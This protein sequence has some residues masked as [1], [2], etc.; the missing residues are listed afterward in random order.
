MNIFIIGCIIIALII[1]T[2]LL[3]IFLPKP[4]CYFTLDDVG[5]SLELLSQPTHFQQILEEYKKNNDLD[6]S[7]LCLLYYNNHLYPNIHKYSKLH[8]LIQSIPDIRS[9]FI[10]RIA[11]K[12]INNIKQRGPAQI[13]NY[14]LRCILPLSISSLNKSGIWVDGENRFFTEQ[15]WIIYDNSRENTYY[16]KHKHRP[17]DLLIIDIDRPAYIPIGISTE[18]TNEI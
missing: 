17:T 15:E 4:K 1:I 7:N 16:N 13:A 3:L 6:Q 8:N 2:M 14:T 12:T 11:P 5:R 10:K 9:L 18:N